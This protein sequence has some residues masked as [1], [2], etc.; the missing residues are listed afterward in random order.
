M[1][2][3]IAGDENAQR[4]LRSEARDRLEGGVEHARRDGIATEMDRKETENR[5]KEAER[6]QAALEKAKELAELVKRIGD[7][8]EKDVDVLKGWSNKELEEQLAV[9]RTLDTEIPLKSKCRT[10]ALMLEAL[11]G[12]IDR[13]ARPPPPSDEMDVDPVEEDVQEVVSDDEEDV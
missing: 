7:R 11:K 8:L 1:N 4:F 2:L 3:R 12:A 10:K 6:K 13:E 9:W 5:A